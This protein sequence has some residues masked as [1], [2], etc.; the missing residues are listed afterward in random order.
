MALHIHNTHKGQ[1][2]VKV[3]LGEFKRGT[4]RSG[5]SGKRVTSRRQAVAIALSE[6]GLARKKRQDKAV[7]SK[8]F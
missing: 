5:G 1:A 3:V 2:K 6:A 4:L 7:K 8:L